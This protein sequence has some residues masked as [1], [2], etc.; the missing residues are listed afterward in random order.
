MTCGNALIIHIQSIIITNMSPIRGGISIELLIIKNTH[1]QHRRC[2]NRLLLKTVAR[3]AK[4]IQK[5]TDYLS[6]M[7]FK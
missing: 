4:Y 7:F 5:L 3:F 2:A 6:V 1:A